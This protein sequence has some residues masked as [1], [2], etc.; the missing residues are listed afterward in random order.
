[1]FEYDQPTSHRDQGAKG[2]RPSE[3]SDSFRAIDLFHLLTRRILTIALVSLA[4][5]C[6][7]VIIG[8]S[9]APR[10]AATA[11]LYVDPRE[12]QLVEREL[13]PRSQD[14]SGLAMVV[15]SQARLI[16]S[17]NV[18][19]KVIGDLSLE[20]DP[21]FG[22]KSARGFLSGLLSFGTDASLPPSSAKATALDALREHVN[23]KRTDRT[24]IVDIEVASREPAKAALL[25]NAIADAYLKESKDSQAA[26]ARRATTDLSGRLKELQE[27]LRTAENDLAIYKSKNNFVGTQDTQVSDQQLSSGTQRLANAQAATLDALARYNQIEASR[28]MAGDSGAMPEALQSPTIASLRTQY[29]DARR[30]QAELLSELGPLHPALR[31]ISKQVEDARRNIDEEVDR[32]AQSANNDLTRARALEASLTKAL[33][34]QKRQ[35][36][37]L[38]QASVQLRELEREVEAS[39]TVYQS[40]LKR[41][42]ETEEQETLNTSSARIIGEATAPQ[43]R[44]FPPATSVL[45]ILGLMLGAIGSAGWIVIAD[46]LSSAAAAAGGGSKPDPVSP[47]VQKPGS[48]SFPGLLRP[49]AGKPTPQAAGASLREPLRFTL[50]EADVLRTLNGIFPLSGT[51]DILRLGWPILNVDASS[52]AFVDAARRIFASAKECSPKDSA[53]VLAVTG[54]DCD[55]HRTVVALNL[56]LALARGGARVLLIDADGVHRALSNRLGARPAQRKPSVWF[57]TAAQQPVKIM[58]GVAIQSAVAMGDATAGKALKAARLSGAYDLVLLDGPAIPPSAL[59]REV[60]KSVDGIIAI[61]PRGPSD[62]LRMKNTRVALGE[63]ESKLMGIVL[64]ELEPNAPVMEPARKS[65]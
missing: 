63:A 26:A 61:T 19:S 17:N 11:Q 52:A 56:A 4:C 62:G 35:S 50:K 8:K 21:E 28:K 44:V 20:R 41:S 48:R 43:R 64:T 13:T 46:R 23:V 9:L 59:D 31:M 2:N 22:G 29:A 10:Y 6:V 5:T 37:D 1:M 24:F 49:Q 60:L 38:G 15:E 36:A 58:S 7:A 18:L 16:T 25:A 45:A 33:E 12:L 34:G 65:A 55:Y 27:R 51:S 42:R 53:P 30:R 14:L 47:L 39:R 32:F 54:M 57:G 3:S 40:F